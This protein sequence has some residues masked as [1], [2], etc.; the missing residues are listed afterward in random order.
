MRLFE[1][2][3]KDA[4]LLLTEG[5][6]HI[7]DQ[8]LP[9]EK[10]IEVLKNIGEFEATEKV[11]GANLWF[12]ID[13]EGKLYTSRGGKEGGEFYNQSDWGSDFKDT[14]FKSAHAALKDRENEIKAAGMNPGD[15]VEVEV[16]FGEKPNAIPYWPNQ[17]IFLR[18]ISG[19]PDIERMADTLEGKTAAAEVENVP[20]TDD[21]KTIERKNEAHKWTFSKVQKYEVD[22]DKIKADIDKHIKKLEVF[23]HK[24]NIAKLKL[25]NKD[26]S[27]GVPTNIEVL[28]LRA[29]KPE[30]KEAKE[31]VKDVIDGDRDPDTGKR[32]GKTGIRFE[33]K[34]IL[35]N[36]LVRSAQSSLG[37]SI[38]DGG[39]IEGVVLR[40]PG[41]GKDG[42]DELFKV[43]DQDV[44]TAVNV[45]NFQVRG[46]LTTKHKGPDSPDEAA[47]I[48][49][50][51]LR[52]MANVIGH[53]QLGTIQAK[54]YLKKL[55]AGAQEIV[56]E[57]A[58]GVDLAST[59]SKWTADIEKTNK[60][61]EKILDQYQGQFKGK[62]FIDSTGRTHKYD[63]TIH[64]RT[65]QVFAELFKDFKAW[66]T[67]I[68]EAKT[69]EELV[70]ILIGDKLV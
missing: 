31:I 3:P 12:G 26:G 34:E 6:T 43:V 46:F 33:I 8:T 1:V 27:I 58:K 50:N 20:Y 14:G 49:G 60:V 66:K 19:D 59:K 35:L 24:P 10:F 52:K 11:D 32:T 18:A 63:E 7:N 64:K 62:E 54:R 68:K 42:G 53:P 69:S 30:I 48:L 47:G 55:G 57:V 41:T 17:I 15:V 28:G 67:A 5:I 38:E 56:A 13:M 23:L 37:P 25:K 29:T 45:F 65:L 44:F 21:G 40:R 16:L 61:L 39:W 9:I 70:M 51:L 2:S 36:N 22:A 4:R